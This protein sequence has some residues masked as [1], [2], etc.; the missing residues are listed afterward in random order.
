MRSR[1]QSTATNL[2]L[3]MVSSTDHITG[4]AGATLT[5]TASKDGGAFSAI[6]PVVTNLGS[7]WYSLALTT[8]HTDTLGDLALHVTAT[9]CDPSDV[10]VDIVA[11]DPE[12][13]TALGISRIDA[14]VTTRAAPGAEMGLSAGAVNATS[15]PNLDAAVSS[16][17]ATAGYTA[18]DNAGITAVKAKTDN[19]PSDP[20]DE[21]ILEAAIAGVASLVSALNNLSSAQ[22]QSAAAAALSAYDGPTN[23]EMVAR[24][25]LAADYATATALATVD[26]VVDTVSGKVVGTL[27]AGTHNP[28]SGDSFTRLGAPVGASISADVTGVKTD[29]ANLND[30]SS[31]QAQAAAAAAVAA[32]DGPTNAEMVART[33]PAG[34]YATTSGI[35]SVQSDIAALNDISTADI[36]A[37]ATAALTS[38]GPAKPADVTGALALLNDVSVSDILA[39]IIEGSLSLATVLRLLLAGMAG[40]T[41][42]METPTPEFMAQDGVTPRISATVD[43]SGNR[44]E[45]TLN[46]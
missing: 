5:I 40:I 43:A 29:V 12:D 8:V 3:L 39:G 37:Q 19:L 2:L 42:G 33:L 24:T 1:K 16:R 15:A 13:A 10:L 30:L 38:Y 6:S 45:V 27:A 20:A 31:A 41:V 17:L 23:A 46:G 11:Y 32:Y 36:L 14:A 28:Q 35:S 25:L 7:G 22:A 26:T 4:V 18:P 34:D 21:S 44:I 9:G